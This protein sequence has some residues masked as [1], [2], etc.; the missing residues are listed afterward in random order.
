GRPAVAAAGDGVAIVAW[1]E[2]G[3]IL[4]RRVWGTSPSVV[5]EQAD[6]ALPGC[7]EV[8]ADEPAIGSGG[9][10]SYAAV[11]FHETLTCNGQTQSRA[12]ENRL[13]GSRYDGLVAADGLPAG[14]AGGGG[15]GGA[16]QPAVAAGEYGR[17]WV[18]SV[19]N[20]SFDVMA[21]PLASNE[22]AG[23]PQQLNSLPDAGPPAPAPAIA[24]FSDAFI[25]WQH[26]PAAGAT[27]DIRMRFGAGAT[28]GPETVLSAGLGGSPDAGS[29][30]TAAGDVSGDGAVAWVQS[31][32]AGNEI[33]ADQLYQ[34]PGA[35]SALR[36]SGY[37]RS[38]R[39]KLVWAP[40]AEAW[41]ARY[42]VALD[43]ATL[44]Q[45]AGT[46]M[47][48]SAPLA[49]GPHSWRVSASNAAGL[50]SGVRTARFFV[51]TIAPR[52]RLRLIGRRR[53]GTLLRL[54][55]ID[56]DVPAGLPASDA[57]GIARTLIGWGDRTARVSARHW[58]EH[59]YR[60]PGRY[61]ITVTVSDRA[62]N[63][64][65]V[66]IVVVVHGK[67]RPHRKG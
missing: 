2:G 25:A 22:S 58:R 26:V 47:A 43:G 29:G 54:Q 12:L 63:V 65:R 6:G 31:T 16:G 14:G 45:T 64:R 10:S 39:P 44:G 9:D 15:A 34:A 13:H 66:T 24:G 42:T 35:P 61:R 46:S 4:T 57:S 27:P 60:R 48:L 5:Y 18:T 49:Q 50:T 55:I 33:V 3:H 56:T 20:G 17:G 23:A 36:P 8:S 21:L 53:A 28:L 59:V 67:P 1:G 51:D 40:S 37:I 19:P 62:G 32:A 38:T 11:A 41:A 30:L 7:S 52:V